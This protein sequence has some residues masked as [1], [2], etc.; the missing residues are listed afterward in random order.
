MRVALDEML[1]HSNVALLENLDVCWGER[2]EGSGEREQK[3]GDEVVGGFLFFFK[4]NY[5]SNKALRRRWCRS[6][7]GPRSTSQGTSLL[8]PRASKIITL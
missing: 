2:E 1:S 8:Q 3:R 5:N 7:T 6:A 4:Q